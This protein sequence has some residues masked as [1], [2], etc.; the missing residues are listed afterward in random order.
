MSRSRTMS[1]SEARLNAV[2][3]RRPEE[4]SNEAIG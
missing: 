3:A 2:I 4:K 1:V